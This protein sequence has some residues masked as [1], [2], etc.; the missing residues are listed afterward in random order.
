MEPDDMR[1]RKTSNTLIIGASIAGL[2]CAAALQK[3]DTGYIIIEKEAETAMPWRNHYER[4]HLHTNK[5]RSNLPFKKFGQKIPRY[6]DRQQV[7]DY[8]DDYQKE[9]KIQPVFNTE[10]IAIR[11]EGPHWITETTNGIFESKQLIMATGAYGKPRPVRFKGLETFPGKVLHS[12]AYKS[13]SAFRDETVLVVGFGNSACEIAIDLYEHGA[14][15]VMAVRSAVNVIPRDLLGVPV[16]ELS[17]L[18]SHFSPRIADAIS[19]PLIRWM[20]GDITKLGL[21]KKPFG[22]LEQISREG[23]APV[24]D[25]GTLQHIRDGHIR[26]YGDIDHIEEDVVYFNDGRKEAF[27]TIVACIGYDRNTIGLAET[28]GDG[29]YF[30]GYRISPT[31]QIREIGSDAK[32]IAKA[33]ARASGYGR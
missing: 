8:I 4:L 13:G 24:L 26:I 5:R 18:L 16:L 7:I 28:E 22:A 15:P 3:Q 9:F 21:R 17:I 1:S 29:L 32:R 30:C 6:P 27:Q 33:I 14:G 19:A 25:I 31:G 12:C 2:A 10:A 23:K 11:K 20:I